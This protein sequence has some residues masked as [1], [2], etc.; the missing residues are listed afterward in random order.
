M[1]GFDELFRSPAHGKQAHVTA[2]PKPAFAG[3]DRTINQAAVAGKIR[4][5]AL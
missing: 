1:L 3:G 4:R 2:R 5:K